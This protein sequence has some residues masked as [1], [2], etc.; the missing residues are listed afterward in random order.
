MSDQLD[1]FEPNFTTKPFSGYTNLEDYASQVRSNRNLDAFVD[2]ET[3]CLLS[4]MLR[5]STFSWSE[6][7]EGS[8]YWNE[9]CE[10]LEI[11]GRNINPRRGDIIH[12]AYTI[13]RNR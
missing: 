12:N 10:R 11:I 4:E 9:V 2:S 8:R 3:I 6:T 13:T 1:L 5:N 7:V